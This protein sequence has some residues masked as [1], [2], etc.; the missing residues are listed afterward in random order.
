MLIEKV[1]SD[2]R[3]LLA[4]SANVGLA[5]ILAA[6]VDLACMPKT[7]SGSVRDNTKTKLNRMVLVGKVGHF[8]GIWDR[9]TR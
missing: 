6:R 1:Y 2:Q 3:R 9:T 4:D 8:D 7:S 5:D